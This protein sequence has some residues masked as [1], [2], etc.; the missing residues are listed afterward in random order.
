MA[1]EKRKA[2]ILISRRNKSP[3]KTPNGH[4]N[5]RKYGFSITEKTAFKGYV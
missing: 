1:V 5:I 4:T 2:F 3:K